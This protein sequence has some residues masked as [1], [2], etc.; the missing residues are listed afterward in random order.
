M[1]NAS[2][3]SYV[4]LGSS[5]ASGPGLDIIDP[6]CS[7]SCNNYP[8]LLA[9]ALGVSLTD[10]TCGGAAVA[11]IM[12]TSPLGQPPQ[13]EA[14]TTA[15]DLVT[16][17]IGGN[18]AQYLAHLIRTTYQHDPEP[19]DTAIAALPDSLRDLIRP[20]LCEPVT[21]ADRAKAAAALDGLADGLSNV[22]VQIRRR[23]PDARIVVVDYV[24][25][26]PPSGHTCAASPLSR[27][28]AS[29]FLD[30]AR[31]LQEATALAAG[32][33]GAELVEASSASDG[34]DVCSKDP[35]VFGFEF[36]DLLGGGAKAFHPNARGM[37]AVAELIARIL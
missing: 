16:L 12:S 30:L 3:S 10:V 8:S 36:G 21:D 6:T 20:A 13:I 7:R 14:V 17:T 4:A 32:C 37:A 22:V 18:D 2:M 35:W 23:A 31:R 19:L 34:H 15:T 27:V 28:E 33:S 11:D 26:L 25:I 1:S 29:Y 9:E 5:F 24:A